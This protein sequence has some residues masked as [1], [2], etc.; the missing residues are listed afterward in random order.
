MSYIS[1]IHNKIN[2]FQWLEHNV[3]FSTEIDFSLEKQ[4]KKEPTRI[5]PKSSR[6]VGVSFIRSASTNF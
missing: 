6:E 2:F 3:N 1:I 4:I 5:E